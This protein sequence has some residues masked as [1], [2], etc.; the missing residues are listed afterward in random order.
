MSTFISYFIGSNKNRGKDVFLGL[1]STEIILLFYNFIFFDKYFPLTE[2]WF[3]VY[4][5][6]VSRGRVPYTDFHLVLPPLYPWILALITGLFGH[7]FIILRLSG[8]VLIFVFALFLFL[9]LSRL[10]PSYIATVA[11]ITGVIYYQAGTAHINYDFIQFLTL[12]GI[13]ASYFVCLYSDSTNSLSAGGRLSYLAIAGIFCSLAILTKQSN[14]MVLFFFMT[15]AVS[16]ICYRK[17]I[18][19]KGTALIVFLSAVCAPVAMVIGWLSSKGA[20]SAFFNQTIIGA[21]A[22]KGSVKAILTAWIPRIIYLDQIAKFLFVC[23]LLYILGYRN[24]IYR[25]TFKNLRFGSGIYHNHYWH[26]AAIIA[27]CF[28]AIYLPYRSIELSRITTENTHFIFGYYSI[29][30]TVLICSFLFSALYYL[31]TIFSPDAVDLLNDDVFTISMTSLAFLIGTGTS[32]GIAEAGSFLGLSLIL[33]HLLSSRSF[34]NIGK[35]TLA[36]FAFILILFCASKKYTAPYTWWGIAEPDI[37]TATTHPRI[38]LLK[39][40]SLSETTSHI[41]EDVTSTIGKYDLTGDD[42]FAFPNIPLFYVLLDKIPKR[43]IFIHWYDVL[44]DALAV[45]EA[46]R[47]DASPPKIILYFRLSKEV[48]SGH[49]MLFRDSKASGQREIISSIEHLVGSGKYSLVKSYEVPRD[50]IL[51]LWVRQL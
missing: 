3:S 32:G 22:S 36:I 14:G 16:H 30:I 15:A 21:S 26:F 33:G 50:N 31:T 28:T 46:R 45:S 35:Y 1:L 34:L 40:F 10:F 44:P 12:F 24:F 51:E 47:I 5:E 27:L 49:E 11:A 23:A 41:L 25:A 7:N 37:R 4:S 19:S 13:I 48:A 6:L 29:I 38:P 39:G 43:F 8:I 42:I 9:M 18:A 17:R 20:L 2:G